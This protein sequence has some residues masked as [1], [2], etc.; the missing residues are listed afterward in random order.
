MSCWTVSAEDIE[1]IEGYIWGESP[2]SQTG[3]YSRSNAMPAQ[4][5]VRAVPAELLEPWLR[6]S[7]PWQRSPTGYIA[8]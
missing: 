7:A 5:R 1:D 8:F 4:G 2:S 6:L 3:R